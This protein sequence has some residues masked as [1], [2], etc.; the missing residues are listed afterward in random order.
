MSWEEY[1]ARMEGESMQSS[2][3][4]TIKKEITAKN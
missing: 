2:C 1:A 4:N 3:G